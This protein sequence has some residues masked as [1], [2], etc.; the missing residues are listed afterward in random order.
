LVI[1]AAW[2]CAFFVSQG[3]NSWLPTLYRTLLHTDIKT[4]L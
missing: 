1:W 3:I 2:F 4:A